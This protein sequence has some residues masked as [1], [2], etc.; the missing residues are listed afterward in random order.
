LSESLV[1]AMEGGDI[2]LHLTDGLKVDEEHAIETNYNF[3][4][5]EVDGMPVIS[6]VTLSCQTIMLTK[7]VEGLAANLYFKNKKISYTV[8]TIKVDDPSEDIRL[9]ARLKNTNR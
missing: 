6:G 2:K 4:D 8:N 3:A 1:I 9:K 7:D 5:E